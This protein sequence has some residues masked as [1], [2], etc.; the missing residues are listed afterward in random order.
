[1]VGRMSVPNTKAGN[2]DLTVIPHGEVGAACHPALPAA[3]YLASLNTPAS[4]RGMESALRT[5]SEILSGQREWQLIDWTQLNA[6]IVQ[7][8]MA[9][10]PGSPATR[11]KLL[12]ALKGVARAAFQLESIDSETFTR[13][14]E[15]RGDRGSRLPAGRDISAG[16]IALLMRACCEDDS[17]FGVRDAAIVA[18][19]ACTGARRAE[20]A[21]LSFEAMEV[22]P[23]SRCRI[24]VTG[25]GN[26]ERW[27][28][29]HNGA[30][31]ALHAWICLRGDQPG[32]LF[33]R[34]GRNRLLQ[35]G[36]ALSQTSLDKLLLKRVQQAGIQKLTWHDFR[37]SMA[38]ALLD[39]GADLSV[40]ASVLGHA[41]VTT[42]I[43]YDRRGLRAQEQAARLISVPFFRR[44][45]D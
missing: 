39:G 41:N 30:Y 15:V 1:M 2:F 17:V 27:L 9:K 7:G 25:K 21:G 36:G 8:I 34:V 33:C 24:R 19:A 13:I 42:T 14:K 12:A 6:A 16:E 31:E 38:G 10:A 32:P 23:D 45:T 44:K 37:R 3:A 29:L 43:R 20:I 5:A 11:N 28:F 26:K 22:L 35:T 18:V 40:V 4:R